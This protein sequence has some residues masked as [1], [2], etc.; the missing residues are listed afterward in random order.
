MCIVAI[1]EEQTNNIVTTINQIAENYENNADFFVYITD[2]N[3]ICDAK[4]LPCLL[5]YKN[6]QKILEISL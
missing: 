3:N 4:A 5:L 2:E 6:G 1:I